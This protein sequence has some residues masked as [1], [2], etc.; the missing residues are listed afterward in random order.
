MQAFCQVMNTKIINAASL[1]PSDEHRD[2]QRALDASLLP[3]DEHKD[4]QRQVMNTKIIN[5]KH[6]DQHDAR[7]HALGASLLPSHQH[8]DQTRYKSPC[9]LA[10]CI[11]GCI[12][13]RPR[14]PP[15]PS[16]ETRGED[17]REKHQGRDIPTQIHLRQALTGNMLY[18]ISVRI[19]GFSRQ[20][21]GA[22][23]RQSTL[24]TCP[25]VPCGK[26]RCKQDRPAECDRRWTTL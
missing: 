1:L 25:C 6:R 12:P 23:G 8:R 5:A 24:K 15:K 11:A 9:S 3:S 4:H 16:A 18:T 7:L 22:H 13:P 21:R 2:H 17:S 20:H 19:C 14:P 10:R 26:Q